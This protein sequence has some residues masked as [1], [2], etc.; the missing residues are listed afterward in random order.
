MVFFVVFYESLAICN[1]WITHFNGKQ[2]GLIFLKIE[3]C[4]RFVMSPGL[5]V[6]D[7]GHVIEPESM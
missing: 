4:I 5:F 6:L 2:I 3:K 7:R 1:W